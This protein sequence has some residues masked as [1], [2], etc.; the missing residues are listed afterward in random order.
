MTRAAAY[1]TR[2]LA[3][4]AA[5]MTLADLQAEASRFDGRGAAEDRRWARALRAEIKNRKNLAPTAPT[6]EG[7]AT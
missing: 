6:N 5:G 1:W 3:R 2:E 7:E 4:R